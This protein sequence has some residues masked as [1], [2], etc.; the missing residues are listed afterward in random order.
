VRDIKIVFEVMSHSF[1]TDSF[2]LGNDILRLKRE[3]D[4]SVSK[5]EFET[6]IELRV[7]LSSLSL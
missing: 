2:Q 7:R 1:H 4:I 3:L 6:A 5:E